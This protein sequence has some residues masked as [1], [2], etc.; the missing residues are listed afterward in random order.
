M[1]QLGDTHNFGQS[2]QLSENWVKKPRPLFWEWLFLS[3]ASPLRQLSQTGERL[4][5]EADPF[6]F[7]PDLKF[8]FEDV[9]RL[10]SSGKVEFC[11]QTSAAKIEGSLLAKG[12]GHCLAQALFWGITDLH[13]E[14]IAFA[15]VSKS[16]QP[17]IFPIDIETIF[18]RQ[19]LLS[20]SSMLKS[21]KNQRI[22]VGARQL[23]DL[24][25][26]VAEIID[27]F[28]KA[29]LFFQEN[30][31]KISTVLT[32]LQ[33]QQYPI[34]CILKPTYQYFSFLKTGTTD[35]EFFS[36]EI[37]QM[38][39]GDIPY[40]YTYLGTGKIL[41]LT[42]HAEAQ[43]AQPWD[44]AFR[45]QSMSPPS[46]DKVKEPL[47][48]ENVYNSALQIARTFAPSEN[49]KYF[50]KETKIEYKNDDIFLNTSGHIKI[51]CKRLR[52]IS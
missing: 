12:F 26:N 13:F 33:I 20:Q 17:L 18:Y 34:R 49:K 5:P 35:I 47:K 19:N 36:E 31:I 39:R 40:F 28:L 44:K 52:P 41:F 6:T 50:F 48:N 9:A 16:K 1:N 27:S 51:K 29:T 15:E 10:K 43:L 42:E 46:L 25:L 14:N 8:N 22:A 2:V 7:F 30:R 11:K 38:K 32:A 45:R 37:V 23:L 24:R 4:S 3:M 21:S